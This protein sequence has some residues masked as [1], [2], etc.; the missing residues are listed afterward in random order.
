MRNDMLATG[1]DKD[2]RSTCCLI[3]E[4]ERSDLPY[5]VS[6]PTQLAALHY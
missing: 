6:N 3:P 2:Q 1:K 5:A 4:K